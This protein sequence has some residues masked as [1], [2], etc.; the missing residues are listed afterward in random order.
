[1][2]PRAVSHVVARLSPALPHRMFGVFWGLIRGLACEFVMLLGEAFSHVHRL[3]AQG[4][5]IAIPSNA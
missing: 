1:M 5:L 3:C 2:E 4:W